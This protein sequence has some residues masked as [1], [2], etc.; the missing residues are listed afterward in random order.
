MTDYNAAQANGEAL[1]AAYAEAETRMQ[2]YADTVGVDAPAK[3]LGD[4]G[5]PARELL[6]F[7]IEYGASLDWIFLGDVRAMIHDSFKVAQEVQA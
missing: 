5:A 3:L 2:F 7:C 4:D 1:R 6:N